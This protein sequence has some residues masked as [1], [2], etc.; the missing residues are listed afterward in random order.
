MYF[1]VEMYLSKGFIFFTETLLS[2]V[3]YKVGPSNIILKISQ[4]RDREFSD[5]SSHRTKHNTKPT[6]KCQDEVSAPF[7]LVVDGII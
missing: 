1:P 3:V 4:M 7:I 6:T 5:V 2:S